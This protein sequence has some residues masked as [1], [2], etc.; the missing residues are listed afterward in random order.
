[1]MN[2]C[3]IMSFPIEEKIRKENLTCTKKHKQQINKTSV[4]ANVKSSWLAI[5]LKNKSTEVLESLDNIFYKTKEI[6][7]PNRKFERKKY[8]YPD[9]KL[10]PPYKRI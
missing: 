7:R 10:S 5:W 8:R 3:A 2:M 6:I 1:M 4:V 9:K